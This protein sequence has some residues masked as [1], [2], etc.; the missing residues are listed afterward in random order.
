MESGV[1]TG[2]LGTLVYTDGSWPR[3]RS[4]SG[5]V[6]HG[7]AINNHRTAN[8]ANFEGTVWR[9]GWTSLGARW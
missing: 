3:L 6:A 7:P 8:Y 2:E 4:V 1:S 5:Q 9:R